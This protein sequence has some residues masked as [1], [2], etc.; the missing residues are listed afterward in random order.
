[1]PTKLVPAKLVKKVTCCG[2]L[3]ELESKGPTFCRPMAINITSGGFKCS[4]WA[5]SLIKLTKAGNVS[6]KN[7]PLVFLNFC[8]FCGKELE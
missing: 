5:V 7:G 4:Q 2:A 3:E 8:P 6:K 1:M